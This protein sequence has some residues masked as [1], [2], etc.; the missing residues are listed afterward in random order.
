[1]QKLDETIVERVMQVISEKFTGPFTVKNLCYWYSV[2]YGEISPRRIFLVLNEL[3][4]DG[5]LRRSEMRVN[6]VRFMRPP[7]PTE[8]EEAIAGNAD[9]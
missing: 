8:S 7:S 3:E 2:R 5:I 6:K 1:M 4:A 9:S